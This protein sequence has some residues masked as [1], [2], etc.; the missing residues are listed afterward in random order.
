MF[1]VDNYPAG[2]N[3]TIMNV[4]Y[5]YSRKDEKTGKRTKD[6]AVIVYKDND[7]GEKHTTTIYEPEYTWYLAKPNVNVGTDTHFL[8][9][10]DTIPITCK[11]NEITRSIAERT[12]QLD[13]YMENIRNGE[14]GLNKSFFLHPRAFSADLPIKNYI[15]S[16]FNETYQNPVIPTTVL[17]FDT[18][19]D[20]IEAVSDNITWGECP[21][22][23]ISAYF[24]GNKTM[25]TMILRNPKN[26]QIAAFEQKIKEC[27]NLDAEFYVH[28]LE[29][30][31]SE[32]RIKK[33]G[34]E[35]SHLVIGFF[36]TEIEMIA[37]FF[38]L[39][40]K[41]DPDFVTAWNLFGY[42][43]IQLI[44][45][46]KALG[47]K[48]EQII[49]DPRIPEAFCEVYTD[50]KNWNKPE[51]R[52]DFADIAVLPSF[53][54][55]EII[56]ASR[57]KGQGAIESFALDHVAGKEAG[58]HKRDYH[59]I[60][61]NIARLPWMNF[62]VFAWYNVGDVIAQ[63]CIDQA[64]EDFSYMFNNVIEMNT[65]YEKVFRQTNFLWTKGMDFYKNVD[66]VVMG[67]NHN[68]FGK[69]PSEKFP[70]AFVA[71]PLLLSDKNKVKINGRSIMKFLN[72]NDF[73]YKALY[74]SLLREFNMA[75]HTQVGMVQFDDPPFQDPQ[76]LRIEAGG[77]FN[78][79]LASYNFIEFAHRW[80]G[81]GNI[82]EVLE[83]LEE[84]FTNYRTPLCR[85][86]GN[87]PYDQTH[88]IAA[89]YIDKSQVVM[90]K[91]P[92]PDWVRLEVNRHR[93]SIALT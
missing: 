76:F 80:M 17:F 19:A 35:G 58:V 26:P 44:E 30:M 69:K 25:Y 10:E 1:L 45:R 79:N 50:E 81:L 46:I 86:E 87:L 40:R 78:E 9:I 13:L 92:M 6:F 32:D 29:Q 36:D 70:G 90:V 15:R 67:N 61:T 89:Y 73:D 62:E 22:N 77:T 66:H 52:T 27:L 38:D 20:I 88:K 54:D 83:D 5:R 11:Y 37:T 93:Q 31:Q 41:L 84:Y 24:T 56:Y 34:L 60:T 28:L 3:L 64:T 33:F 48:P 82:D 21:T 7:T 18:E 4:I 43:L 16:R 63:K 65:P 72:A 74:P 12:G 8:D 14:Q 53:Q 2:S 55:Q 71:S 57:R 49:C 75:P 47:Y 51:E 59:Y 42:D 68:R 23:M 85:G 91:R 39:I